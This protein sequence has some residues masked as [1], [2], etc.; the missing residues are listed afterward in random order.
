MSGASIILVLAWMVS[1]NIKDLNTGAL[2]G[3]FIESANISTMLFP[4]IIFAVSSF[5]AFTTG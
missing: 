4:A 5:L 1:T 3:E 2:I